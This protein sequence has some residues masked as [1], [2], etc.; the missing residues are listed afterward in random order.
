MSTDPD[1]DIE[2]YNLE[3]ILNLFHLSENF[4]EADLKRAK[5][6]VLRLHPDK[7]RLDKEYFL[8]Y[9]KAYKVVYSIFEFNNKSTKKDMNTDEYIPLDT[10]EENKKLA[11][12]TFF[13]KNK[14][15]QKPT[16][17][18]QWFNK[19]FEKQKVADE[20]SE[21]GYGD[22][23]TS[24]ENV[25]EETHVTSMAAMGEQFAKRKEEVRSL[26][27]H[28]GVNEICSNN[29]V[30][31]SDLA[32]E[33]L[34]NYS[35]DMFSN[36]QFQDLKQAHVESVIPVTDEDYASVPKFKNVNEYVTH[37]N[38]QDTKPLSEQQALQYLSTREKEE[39]SMSTKRAYEL[40]RQTEE[41]K[42]RSGQFW[43]GLMK[44]EN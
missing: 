42:K 36:V 8:F 43:A 9:S 16:N 19:E 28:Q 5:Q 22:W 11:L 34:G 25:M 41:A 26:V 14:K 38:T 12:A 24:D 33:S 39:S 21:T 32:G 31:A 7:S 10:N 6:Q 13:E 23:L 18:N 44:I 4:T 1:L 17:F 30:G 40:A 35:S 37:R 29:S 3:D 15:L 27:V 20:Q 2:N